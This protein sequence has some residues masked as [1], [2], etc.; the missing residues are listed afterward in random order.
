[1]SLKLLVTRRKT[2]AMAPVVH[3]WCMQGLALLAEA[4]SYIPG[5]RSQSVFGTQPP[6]AGLALEPRR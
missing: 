1:M 5:L 2:Q 3:S 4:L 6:T